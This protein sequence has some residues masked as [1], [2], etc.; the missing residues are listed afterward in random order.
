MMNA[1]H[2]SREK[3]FTDEF[4]KITFRNDEEMSAVLGKIEDNEFLTEMKEKTQRFNEALLNLFNI[5]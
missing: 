4:R 5:D 3:D 1:A 2:S